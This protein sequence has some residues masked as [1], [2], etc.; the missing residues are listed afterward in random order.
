[1]DNILEMPVL[2]NEICDSDKDVNYY[3]ISASVNTMKPSF[4]VFWRKP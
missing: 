3:F 1:M 4:K 2:R